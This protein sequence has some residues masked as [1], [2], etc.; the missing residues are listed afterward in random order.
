MYSVLPSRVK[1]SAFVVS[2]SP[3]G[4][5]PNDFQPF[6]RALEPFAAAVGHRL[7][8]QAQVEIVVGGEAGVAVV[9]DQAR[10]FGG[11]Q[12]DADRIEVFRIAVVRADQHFVRMFRRQR[13][14]IGARVLERRDVGRLVA[15]QID[16]VEVEIL[17]AAF[18][19]R[20]QHV[21]AVVGERE[22]AHAAFAVVRD[23]FRLVRMFA[24]RDEDVEHAVVRRDVAEPFAVGTDFAGSLLRI[25]EQHVPRNDRRRGRRR[26]RSGFGLLGGARGE[27]RGE[28]SAG[29][30]A[31][32]DA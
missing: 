3:C 6:L 32:E 1:P 22:A 30:E 11:A 9:L 18:V 21:F 7:V 26:R 25:A 20:I 31:D 16:A 17:V 24:R 15:G 5:R 10:A 4:T 23:H 13:G 27:Q 14:E 2:A 19:L 29:S 12:I 8:G 28:D